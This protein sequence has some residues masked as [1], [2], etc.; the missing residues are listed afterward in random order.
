MKTKK[1]LAEEMSR[2]YFFEY[3][4]PHKY[5]DDDMIE[6]MS[7]EQ[8]EQYFQKSYFL[9]NFPNR[10]T[11]KTRNLE[12]FQ[13]TVEMFSDREGF[14]PKLFVDAVIAEQFLMPQQFPYEKNWKI[15]LRNSQE[16][17]A[18]S[19]SL[20]E[21]VKKAKAFFTFLNGRSIKDMTKSAIFSKEWSNAYA[22]DTLDLTVLCFS[23]SFMEFAEKDNMIIDFKEEQSKIDERLK[24]K[25]KEKLGE[26][27]EEV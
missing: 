1:E 8:K 5:K 6:N 25:I 11:F 13:K 27:F 17:E 21:D 22:D 26:D 19:C 7:Y 14:E 9:P 15:F 23:K 12:Y 4:L 20:V 18:V 3:Y 24:N 2:Y 16:S 10:P